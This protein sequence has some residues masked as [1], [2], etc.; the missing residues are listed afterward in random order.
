ML[1]GVHNYEPD[2][3]AAEY[4]SSLVPSTRSWVLRLRRFLHEASVQLAKQGFD[5][6]LD[7]GSGLPTKEHIHATVPNARVVYVDNDPV[8]VALGAEI[9]GSN[10]HARYVHADIRDIAAL[11]QAPE[12]EELLGDAQRVAIGFNAITCFLTD[13]EVRSIVRALYE[14]APSGSKMFATFETKVTEAMTPRMLE[15]IDMFEKMGSPYHF[16]TLEGSKALI[17]PWIE[18]VRGFRPLF[19]WLG[20]KETPAEEREGVGLEFYGAFL[21]KP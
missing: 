2:R 1:G 6:F 5:R 7:L 16:L 8:V 21:V 14:W 11:L 18:D 3:Q 12:I 10:S 15:F 20:E 4:L 17:D 13:E 19:E 9:L